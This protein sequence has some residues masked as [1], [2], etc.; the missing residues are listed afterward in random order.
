M[1]RCYIMSTLTGEQESRLIESEEELYR[2]F[3]PFAKPVAERRIGLEWEIFG[4]ERETGKG[5]F[6]LG[7]RGIEAILCRLAAAFHYEPILEEG[8][9]IALKRGGDWVTLEP[10]GQV[11]LSASPVKTVFEIEN[12]LKTF[13]GELKEVGKNYFPGMTWLSVGM[14]PFSSLDEISWVPKRRYALM[15]SYLK[16]K[17]ALAHD[18][19]KR[20]ATNQLN[21]D[22]PDEATA[23]AQL[24]TVFGITSIVSALFANSSFSEGKPNGFLTRRVQIWN[25]TDPARTG[26][27]RELIQEGTSFRDYI[28]YLLDMP[29]IFI[30]RGEKWIPMEG[31]SFRKFLREGKTGERATW[32]DFELHL[33]T[34]FPEA[35]FKHYLEIRGV[36]AQRFPF[37]PAVA[38]FWKGILYDDQS[39]QASWQLVKDFSPEER[40]KLHSALPKEG[41]KARFGRVPIFELAEELVRLSCEGLRR[42]AM[43]SQRSEEVYLESIREEILKPRRSPAETLLKKWSEEFGQDS[44]ALIRYLEI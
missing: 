18:M 19:M 23:L 27:L 2:F 29:M 3:Q 17:G 37:I 24:R 41:L 8:H 10:G 39:R 20:T 33:S 5:L 32:P 1:V 36:D 9:V 11:E 34:A 26:L 14:H 42:Q 22:F 35:R 44:H 30:V 38:A 16:S 43:D 6:Y 4:V 7:P 15:A 25:E 28:E 12:Q 21:L 40:L 13:A 31:I